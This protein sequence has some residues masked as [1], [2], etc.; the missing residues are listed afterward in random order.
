LCCCA[1][2]NGLS[3]PG[4]EPCSKILSNG[5]F[6]GSSS[7]AD[8]HLM[9]ALVADVYSLDSKLATSLKTQQCQLR[10]KWA[11]LGAD[12]A[13]IRFYDVRS[14]TIVKGRGAIFAAGSSVFAVFDSPTPAAWPIPVETLIYLPAG[15]RRSVGAAQMLVS[16]RA[17]RLPG[18][19]HA[20]CFMLNS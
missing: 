15:S 10:Q 6:K 9:A 1:G 17:V 5:Y 14:E 4:T 3:Q 13:S 16:V 18:A 19:L 8:T 7:L 12:F 2:V 20:C 11:A